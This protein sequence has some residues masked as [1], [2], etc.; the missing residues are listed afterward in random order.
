MEGYFGVNESRAQRAPSREA[1]GR[2]PSAPLCNAARRRHSPI[3]SA[4][5]ES[6]EMTDFLIDEI[7]DAIPITALTKDRLPA[8]LKEAAERERNWATAT[9]FSAEAG[10]LALVPSDSGRLARVL[11]GLG[12][13][14]GAD[15]A[16]WALAGLP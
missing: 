16:M 7:P 15:G 9:G 8:W 1:A 3:Q 12:E 14:T 11:V 5:R 10:K 13:R 2:S 4:D 6:R